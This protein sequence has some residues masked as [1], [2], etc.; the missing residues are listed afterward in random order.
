A[1]IEDVRDGMSVDGHPAGQRRETGALALGARERL[2]AQGLAPTHDVHLEALALASVAAALG[3]VERE[4]ARVELG[5]APSARGTRAHRRVERG[6]VVDEDHH[7][8]VGELGR[9][10]DLALEPSSIVLHPGADEL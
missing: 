9:A 2:F 8:A 10:T 3:G 4:E 1:A 5:E 7:R 6:H